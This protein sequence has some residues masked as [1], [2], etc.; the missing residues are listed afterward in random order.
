MGAVADR[1]AQAASLRSRPGW[2][3]RRALRLATISARIASTAPSRPL[4][5]PTARPD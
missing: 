4:G 2:T 5:A 1:C 3:P